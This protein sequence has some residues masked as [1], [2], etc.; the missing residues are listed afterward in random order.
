MTRGKILFPVQSEVFFSFPVR[1]RPLT[2]DLIIVAI[3]FCGVLT[4]LEGSIIPTSLPS[5]IA[6]LGGG[7]I[8]IWASNGYYVAMHVKPDVLLVTVF[9]PLQGQLAN[10]FGRRWPMII[11]TA[12]FVLGSGICGGATNMEM[13]I[14]GRVVQ[15]IGAGGIN[16]L[17]EIIVCDLVPL[18]E[19][20][21]YFALTFGCVGLGAALGPFFGGLIVQHSTWRWVFYL[22]LPIGGLALALLFLFLHTNYNR[23]KTF[24][25]KLTNIDWA[26]NAIFVASVTSILVGL[27]W[28]GTL[29]PW[30][31]YQA[32][33][34]LILGFAGLVGFLFFESYRRL[35]PQPMV[36]I[37]LMSNRTS[38]TAFVLAFVQSMIT[39]WPLFF[40]PIY[41]QGVLRAS[42]SI[43]GVMLLPT[44]L[45]LIPGVALGGGA[46][47][48]IGRYRPVQNVGF[49]LAI[50]GFGLFTMLDENSSTGWWIGFQILQ[51][52]G[53]GSV[54]PTVLPAIL[55]PLA[56]SD[57]ALAT[58][59]CAFLRSFGLMWGTAIPA[60]VFNTR[61]NQLAPGAI[62]D[63]SVVGALIVGKAYEHATASFVNSLAPDTAAQ[64]TSVLSDSLK[65]AWQVGIAVSGVSFFLVFVEREVPLRKKLETEYGI[66]EK[67]KVMA[68]DEA[69]EAR[70]AEL[71]PN[72]GEA[73]N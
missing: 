70:T 7:D 29:H 18:S 50:V 8:Y 2:T 4:A 46:M 43:S 69:A 12:A 44:I 37:H 23:E 24:A 38:A 71:T 61:F 60:A 25:D 20:G 9:Q 11:S 31:S 58:A 59:L 47:T 57:T 55:A 64:L 19:R 49:A 3:V 51:S 15:G 48:K 72:E 42:S 27:A 66:V 32:L 14:V 21:S 22:N 13:L 67:K 1:T 16:V 30:S 73:K 39:I 33:V 68:A 26:G 56:E 17:M 41:F 34:P 62:T 5:I 52:V 65:L 6:D 45:A 28:A 53:A 40:L 36:P 35:A 10:V 63:Q 54:M